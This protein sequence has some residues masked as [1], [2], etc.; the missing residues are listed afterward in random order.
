MGFALD[1]KRLSILEEESDIL[2]I[3]GPGSGKTTISILKAFNNIEMQKLNRGQK[4]LFL[5]FSRNAK[6]R[7][8]ESSRKFEEHK[9]YSS[10]MEV[11]TFHGFFLEIVK[12]HG[13]L[14]GAKKKV[15]IVPPHDEKVLRLG[16][17]DESEDWIKEREEI[18]LKEGNLVFDYFAP[19]ALEILLKGKRILSL[20]ANKYPIIIVDEAQD[21]D[22]LQW[23]IIKSFAGK[24]QLVIMADLQ[25]Q[26][27]DY[28]PDINPERL[29]EIKTE[30]SPVEFNLETENHRSPNK[31]ILKFAQ[32]MFNQ[33][34]QD[35]TYRGI[36]GFGFNVINPIQVLRRA[37]G[38]IYQNAKKENREAPESIG[39]F[40]T[41]NAGV[42]LVSKLLTD[43]KIIHKY[44]F[45]EVATN[46]S[47]KL[48]ACLLEPIFDKKQH[49]LFC[50]FI[51]KEY[52]S[53]KGKMQEIQKFEKWI[54]NI[55]Q[56]KK[57][58]GTIVPSL[59]SVIEEIANFKFTG[60][61]AKDWRFIQSAFLNCGNKSL[62]KISRYSENLVAFNRGKQ[63]MIGLTETWDS[64]G[65]YVDARGVLQQALIDTQINNIS[66]KE[67]GINLMNMHQS[68][69]KEFDAVIIFENPYSC[70]FEIRNDTDDLFK[71]RKL[72]FVAVTR[73]KEH[74][75]FVRQFGCKSTILNNAPI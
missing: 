17:D 8:L 26:I 12:S 36:D 41:T 55:R 23:N 33:S 56:D 16:R 35:S 34:Y 66:P 1:K 52:Y 5:S 10:A 4:V 71:I 58:A 73:A 75:I 2:I 6:A 48:I 38:M 63:I 47:S 21:T 46:L 11:M 20:Y 9:K 3:G 24:S 30:L 32:D 50:L 15:N 61:P 62:I 13:Y 18:F 7:I 37:I 72:L 74:L 51:I 22:S 54:S 39:I 70:S 59:R 67:S 60:N 14:L 42:K 53:S 40:C 29:D 19:K 57:V 64:K 65:S 25:Q 69:G 28:R 45:D 27:Y 31:D 49:L 43:A 44:Q 68:K